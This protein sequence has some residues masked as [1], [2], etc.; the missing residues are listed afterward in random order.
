MVNLEPELVQLEVDPKPIFILP[1]HLDPEFEQQEVVLVQ[2]FDP[3]PSINVDSSTLLQILPNEIYLGPD[4]EVLPP[5]LISIEEELQ[6]EKTPS[7]PTYFG[8]GLHLY[9]YFPHLT[10]CASTDPFDSQIPVDSL[11]YLL[12]YLT[13][14]ETTFQTI[15]YVTAATTYIVALSSMFS[16]KPESQNIGV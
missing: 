3:Q 8:S 16:T 2:L 4:S 12:G 13:M 10:D 9:Q 6:E 5:G 15:P 7:N 11:E 1:E 14:T